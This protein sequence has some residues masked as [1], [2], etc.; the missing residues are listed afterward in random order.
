MGMTKTFVE[1]DDD[2]LADAAE[3]SGARTTKDTVNAAL[4][5]VSARRRRRRALDELSAMADRG[6]F[7][8]FTGNP[9]SYRP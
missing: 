6:D 4:R 1:I 8:E 5:E 3:V 2:A 7:D 9:T